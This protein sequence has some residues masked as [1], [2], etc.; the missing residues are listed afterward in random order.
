M[1]IDRTEFGSITIDG[2]I[3]DHDVIID[4]SGG[5][6]KRKKRLSKET[7]RKPRRRR[8]SKRAASC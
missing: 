7:S 8:S 4:L 5:V 1:K 2:K 3:Y 6:T